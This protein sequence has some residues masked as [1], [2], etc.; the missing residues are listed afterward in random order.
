MLKKIKIMKIITTLRKVHYLLICAM[1][2][3]GAVAQT[4]CDTP[5]T[6]AISAINQV[7]AKV[8]W[9]LSNPVP[10]NGYQIEVRTSGSAGAGGAGF[11]NSYIIPANAN[12]ANSFTITGLFPSTNYKVYLK[13]LCT[14][15]S[16]D[17]SLLAADFTTLALAAPVVAEA[18]NIGFNA[19]VAR[20]ETSLG[21]GLYELQF[22]TVNPIPS[23]APILSTTNIYRTLTGLSPNTDYYYHVRAR[24]NVSSPPTAYSSQASFTTST[25][26][27]TATF[28]S[29]G[30]VGQP[31]V[32]VD[33]V[34]DA[35]Y[36]TGSDE[37][38]TTLL[39]RKLT[40]NAGKTFTIASGTIVSLQQ[41]IINNSTAA[42]F[43][44]ESN[45]N[46]KQEIGTSSNIG[47]ITVKRFSRNIFRLDYTMWSSP[48]VGQ[49]LLSFSPQTTNNR[50]YS[51][52]TLTNAYNTVLNPGSTTFMP[53]K[54]FLVRAPNTWPAYTSGAVGTKWE[55]VFVGQPT[56]G[57]VVATLQD[58]PD[59]NAGYNLVGNPYPGDVFIG[60]VLSASANVSNIEQT[61]WIWYR[62][63]NATALTDPGSFYATVNGF[64]GAG[65]P[66]GSEAI[67]DY[68]ISKVGQG[69]IV[70]T[71]KGQGKTLT[72]TNSYRMDAATDADDYNNIFIRSQQQQEI[73][74]HKLWLNLTN[75]EGV[76]SEV[77]LG[78]ASDALD[79]KDKNDGEYIGDS[80]VALTSIIEDIAYTIQA[81]SLPFNASSEF[82]LKVQV[83]T[84][85]TYNIAL[86]NTSGMFNELV[87][88]LLVDMLTNTTTNLRTGSYSFASEVGSFADRFKV[89]F[90]ET[91]LGTV[92]NAVNENAVVV[93]NSNGV[94]GINA[95]SYM[96][97]AVEIYDLL[98]RRIH[99]KSNV[100][101][102]TTTM[103]DLSIN[104][105]VILVKIFTD[106]GIVTKKVQF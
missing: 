35:N 72:F 30:W 56:S 40:I 106:H 95:G 62:R 24:R 81:K 51:Y 73:E 83:S 5:L 37:Y 21:A 100:D 104:Q 97:N 9:T 70:K 1:I 69:F 19:A 84:A 65:V 26:T 32:G 59:G 38:G 74:R 61:A 58:G 92:D 91:A 17:W 42:S 12:P 82:A 96:I 2:S 8:T 68:Y 64:G 99:S 78:F 85:G 16:S 14:P 67:D 52:N 34:I 7:S 44:I 80:P 27:N 63:N 55:G 71:K 94:L 23:N 103:S 102:N 90:E 57:N 11:I 87:D 66:P 25:N 29:I 4:P 98:G 75:E 105:Q 77:L 20:W 6:P 10:T 28:T 101:A 54:A 18:T 46:L 13:A 48:V 93:T 89:I 33:I 76:F 15:T 53:G 3:I 39:G 36:N 47:S 50:F 79:E 31:V 60:E 49:N 41:G 86:R 43:V 22:S 88:P 45:G